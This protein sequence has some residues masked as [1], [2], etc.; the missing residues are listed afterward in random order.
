M[1]K[2][3]RECVHDQF[4]VDKSDISGVLWTFQGEHANGSGGYKHP[5][6]LDFSRDRM[7]KMDRIFEAMAGILFESSGLSVASCST[8]TSGRS[9]R[10]QRD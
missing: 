4:I 9:P 10:G 6:S 2:L 5:S 3:L 8:Y 1:G 7:N